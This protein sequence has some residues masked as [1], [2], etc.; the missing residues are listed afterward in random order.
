[1]AT[2]GVSATSRRGRTA[3]FI[4]RQRELERLEQLWLDTRDGRP[5]FVV[6]DGD[7]GIGK[8]RLAEEF[9]TRVR[10]GGARTLWGNCVELQ[11]G[12]LPYAP[13]RQALRDAQD[14]PGLRQALDA[15][16]VELSDLLAAPDELTVAG[17]GGLPCSRGCCGCCVIWRQR[18]D[19]SC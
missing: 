13:F 5:G 2:D 4:G 7:A 8:T 18:T 14:D 19:R 17:P 10:R 9:A 6:I 16:R 11:E 1:M 3:S 12:G 15:A